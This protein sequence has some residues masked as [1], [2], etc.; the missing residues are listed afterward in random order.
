MGFSWLL[1]SMPYGA[2]WRRGRKLMHSHLGPN[3]A[4]A[5]HVAQV[6]AARAFVA[7][8]LDT[9][10]TPAA[11]PVV[12]RA[13]FGRMIVKI[14]YGKDV[15]DGD[16]FVRVP[17]EV[18]LRFNEAGLPGRFL[19]DHIPARACRRTPLRRL[20]LNPHVQSSMSP[21]GCLARGFSGLRAKPRRCTRACAKHRSRTYGHIWYACWDLRF[22]GPRLTCS[23]RQAPHR[24]R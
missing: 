22:Q 8:L 17:A 2:R 7:Q 24:C 16:D 15:K 1:S 13:Y 14:V 3:A 18:L 11:L 19:V 10:P 6:D 23:R 5:H 12:V 4:S 9:P 20:W 21:H